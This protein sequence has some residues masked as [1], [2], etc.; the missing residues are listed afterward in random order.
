[1]ACRDW[2]GSA[3]PVDNS[4]EILETWLT[5]QLFGVDPA[6]DSCTDYG[7]IDYTE[8]SYTVDVEGQPSEV[9]ALFFTA[10][11]PAERPE[12]ATVVDR[13]LG[14]LPKPVIF[15]GIILAIPPTLGFHTKYTASSHAFMALRGLQ[16]Q[17]SPRKM[18]S[19]RKRNSLVWAPY[20]SSGRAI[21]P[22][23]SH[24]P[25]THSRELRRVPRILSNRIA[26]NLSGKREK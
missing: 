20:I 7:D 8:A 2:S 26:R 18:C 12:N 22:A 25:R 16:H 19:L 3:L 13:I 24:A 6:F 14:L 15:F 23:G 11:V 1:M 9:Q 4:R 10:G 21:R 17:T 5:C